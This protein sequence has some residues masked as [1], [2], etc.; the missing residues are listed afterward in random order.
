M[1]MIQNAYQ[2]FAK[3][4]YTM[5]DNLKLGYGGT[6]SEMAR[7]IN[8]SGVLGKTTKVTAKTV[9]SVS[10]DKI[11]EAIGVMQ[12]RMGITGTTAKEAGATISGSV[13]AMKSAWTNL[14]TGL[15]DDNADLEKLIDNLVTTIVGDGTDANLGVLGN[16]LPAVKRSL[17]G[18]SKLI[19]K[20]VPQIIKII[21]GILKDNLPVLIKAAVSILEGIV[22]SIDE[23]RDELFKMVL[24]LIEYL[25]DSF[26]QMLPKIVELGLSLIV[27]LAKG[28]AKSI[29]RLVPT[30]V[31]VVLKIVDVLTDPETLSELLDAAIEIINA[32]SD[33]LLEDET[34]D[35][36]IDAC[37]TIIITI[38]ELL[39]D[40]VDKLVDAAVKIISALVEYLTDF[41]NFV[42]IGKAGADI[43]IALG[44]ALLSAK[45]SLS[46]ACADLVAL[47]VEKFMGIDLSEAG[48]KAVKKFIKGISSGFVGAGFSNLDFLSGEVAGAVKNQIDGSHKMGLDYV[49]YDGYIAELHK[50]E[51]VLTAKEAR[52]YSG[53][54][55]YGDI[56]INIDGERY[57]DEQSLALAVAEAIQSMTDRRSAV[58]A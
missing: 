42:E 20:S 50:G 47:I 54:N 58:Y 56:I 32:L 26:I 4:N 36:L 23:N 25:A 1:E 12:D 8:D 6:A 22:D 21:P 37:A 3:Q 18:V 14:I 48:E 24:D 35:Q 57:D 31:D 53:G 41:E 13:G 40:N 29:P 33:A 46:D 27:N 38:S 16:V 44:D 7:L 28:I 9:N 55:S 2:G 52:G 39:A 34:L 49:P 30:I 19:Q 11:I 5:L 43:V 15:A 17:N 45:D 51:R 10:F